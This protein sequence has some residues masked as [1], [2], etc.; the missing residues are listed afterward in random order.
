MVKQPR[1]HVVEAV[2]LEGLAHPYAQGYGH[3]Q[4]RSHTVHEGQE[5]SVAPGVQELQAVDG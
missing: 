3:Q 2:V 1:T 5:E 4:E